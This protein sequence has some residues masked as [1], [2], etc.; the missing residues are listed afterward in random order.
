MRVS[1]VKYARLSIIL[2]KLYARS[3]SALGTINMEFCQVSGCAIDT[4]NFRRLNI[5]GFL[6]A[7]IK[8]LRHK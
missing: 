2:A 6:T 3:R 7:D 4:L 5:D 8:N 1:S